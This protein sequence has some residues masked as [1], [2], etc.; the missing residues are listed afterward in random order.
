MT[1]SEL[2]QEIERIGF[3]RLDE[4]ADP[5]RDAVVAA[6]VRVGMAVVRDEF[7]VDCITHELAR[8]GERALDRGLVPFFVKPRLGIKLA[9]GYWPPG[10]SAGAHEHTAWTIT[11]VCRNKLEVHTYD[12]AESYRRG[13][14]VPKN[15]FKAEAGQTGFIYE[16]CIHD[17]RNASDDWSLSLHVISPLDGRRLTDHE[18]SPSELRVASEGPAAEHPYARVRAARRR[19]RFVHQLTRVLL[20]TELPQARLALARCRSLGLPVTRR[21]I[22]S[23][24]ND[25]GADSP[26]ILVRTDAALELQCRRER[27]TAVLACRDDGGIVDELVAD[28]AAQPA[29]AHAVT[30]PEVEVDALPGGLSSQESRALGEALESTG[31]FTRKW[32]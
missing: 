8:L 26:Y 23:R 6:R 24:T 17:P 7:L 29:I 18:A 4:D 5:G 32:P 31:L 30:Q 20:G 1:L 25:R 21:L 14:L 28:E 10:S 11:A 12:R 2:C 15:H 19:R 27:G 16:P 9:F 22:A 3:P 13:A